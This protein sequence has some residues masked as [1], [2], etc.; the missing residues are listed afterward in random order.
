MGHKNCSVKW[1]V[2]QN[3]INMWLRFKR[4]DKNRSSKC[5]S[6]SYARSCRLSGREG[7]FSSLS[8]FR[9]WGKLALCN[10]QRQNALCDEQISM[11]GVSRE[12][13]P[14]VDNWTLHNSE[15]QQWYH[16]RQTHARQDHYSVTHTLALLVIIYN[17]DVTL[18]SNAVRAWKPE[19]LKNCSP[20]TNCYPRVKMSS[21]CLLLL[22]SQWCTQ[23]SAQS[24]VSE[25][26]PLFADRRFCPS[27]SVNPT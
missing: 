27:S 5:P 17:D 3:W 11:K 1:A 18:L 14:F 6:I 4:G 23:V 20:V 10:R 7:Y 12:K 13:L 2:I 26:F 19:A 8:G 9:S 22:N 25:V 21:C 15:L 16:C 24:G